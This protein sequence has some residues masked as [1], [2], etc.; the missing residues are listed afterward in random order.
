MGPPSHTAHLRAPSRI[1]LTP[2]A[3]PPHTLSC[4][5]SATSLSAIHLALAARG[6]QGMPVSMSGVPPKAPQTYVTRGARANSGGWGGERK[7]GGRPSQYRRIGYPVG[8]RPSEKGYRSV[9]LGKSTSQMTRAKSPQGWPPCNGG[10]GLQAP[11]RPA[12]YP[13]RPARP[14]GP[15]GHIGTPTWARRARFL[16]PRTTTEHARHTRT[17]ACPCPWLCVRQGAN[18]SG[19]IRDGLCSLR[20]M[21]DLF[22]CR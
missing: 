5:H 21:C 18:A 13:A 10:G 14:I 2:I 3:P 8:D 16:A 11:R 4:A 17:R 7:R 1:W 22:V 20:V 9:R 6:C 12:R 15:A 19:L